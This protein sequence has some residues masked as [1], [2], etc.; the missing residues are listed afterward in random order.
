[1]QLSVTVYASAEEGVGIF[2]RPKY[3][4]ALAWKQKQKQ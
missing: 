3:T 4:Y 2:C 1:M